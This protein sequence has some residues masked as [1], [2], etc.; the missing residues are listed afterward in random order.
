MTNQHGG[1]RPNSGR[2]PGFI[3]PGAAHRTRRVILL[4]DEEHQ[5]AKD[6]GGGNI[7][8]GIRLALELAGNK[9]K[10]NHGL[11]SAPDTSSP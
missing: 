6:I 9:H 5:L 1:Y 3:L 8:A 10:A 2:K 4:S 11:A 7:S